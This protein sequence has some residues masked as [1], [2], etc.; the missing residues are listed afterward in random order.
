MP[1]ITASYVKDHPALG[2]DE[3][4][5]GLWRAKVLSNVDPER[6]GRLQVRVLHLHPPVVPVQAA[7]ASVAPVAPSPGIPDNLCPWAEPAFP[8]GGNTGSPGGFVMLPE[9]GSTVWVGFEM[10]HTG[11]PVWFGSWLGLSEMPP[12]M[13]DPTT[14]R[15]IRTPKGGILSF[16]DDD[17]NFNV[18][19]GTLSAP[20]VCT[21]YLWID[22]TNLTVTLACGPTGTGSSVTLKETDVEVVL[23]DGTT[24][25]RVLIRSAP[26]AIY[27]AVGAPGSGNMIQVDATG[28][29]LICGANSINLTA[30]GAMTLT[31]VLATLINSTGLVSLGVGAVKGVALNS[32]LDVLNLFIALFNTHTHNYTDDGAP[33]V[34]QTPNSVAVPGVHGVDT[35]TTVLARN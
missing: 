31:N 11:Y 29:Q 34:T 17:S 28:V 25:Q 7:N 4:R 10:G 26:P 23:G 9:I 30:A 16:N 14:L 33:M 13:S 6:R 27:I 22:E 35:S 20:N 32:L 21:R 18:F 5:R 24:G 19:L 12:E 3:T 15:M 8:F 1:R 2:R